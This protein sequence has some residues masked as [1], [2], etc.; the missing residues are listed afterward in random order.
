[1]YPPRP[2]HISVA[3]LNRLLEPGTVTADEAEHALTH[4]GFPIESRQTLPDG[5]VMLDVEVTSNRGD[6]LCHLGCAREVAAATGRRLKPRAFNLATDSLES[7]SSRTSVENRVPEECPLFTAR[8]IRG[9]KVGPSPAWMVS[10][11]A[12]VG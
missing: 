3:W 6:V 8:L 4:M 11:L 12:A 9:V 1:M 10:A 5:D 2:M 7:A